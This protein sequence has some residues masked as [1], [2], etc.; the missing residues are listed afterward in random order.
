[1]A[2]TQVILIVFALYFFLREM[3]HLKKKGP[4]AYFLNKWILV[5]VVPLVLIFANVIH[6]STQESKGQTD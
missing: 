3:I 5:D 2:L 4:K 1:M 6:F